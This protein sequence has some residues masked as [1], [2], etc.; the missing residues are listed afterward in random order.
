MAKEVVVLR[1]FLG[2]GGDRN[3]NFLLWLSVPAGSEIPIPGGTSDWAG[4]SAA[5]NTAIAN[6]QILEE[7]YST[8]YPQTMTVAQIK[9]DLVSRYN[10]RQAQVTARPNPN[11]F[12][13]VFF[14][15]VSGWSA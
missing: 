15:S 7:V 6:G 2:P 8:Q 3:V 9:A 10:A 5:E 13:G 1:T 11:Q 4:A 14:D 12:Y